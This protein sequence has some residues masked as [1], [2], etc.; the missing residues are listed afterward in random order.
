MESAMRQV[1]VMN[2]EYPLE[3]EE[4]ARPFELFSG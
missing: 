4:L 2:N 1:A 3:T